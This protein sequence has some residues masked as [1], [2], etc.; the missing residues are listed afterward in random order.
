[1]SKTID[2]ITRTKA[3]LDG[4]ERFVGRDGNGD[5]KA[6]IK[7]LRLGMITMW[8]G[9]VAPTGALLC[10][11]SAISRTTY[12]DLFA[13]IGTTFGAGDNSTTF[14]LPNFQGVVPKGVGSQTINTR[15]KSGPSLGALQEDQMQGHYHDLSRPNSAWMSDSGTQ[16]SQTVTGIR[17]YNLM[18]V[19]SPVSD[20]T[21]GTPRTGATTREN[22]L[23]IN[24]IV[25]Y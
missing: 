22:C 11:G 8:G 3:A 10:D 5:F 15:S 25:W 6:L 1:M 24:F 23:G 7:S 19:A 13:I 20:G 4:T 12:A 16:D 17:A 9:A 2:E 21:N 14:N 18:S